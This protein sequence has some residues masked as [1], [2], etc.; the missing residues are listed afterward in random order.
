MVTKEQIKSNWLYKCV[1][2]RR[3]AV[4]AL[5]AV[6]ERLEL[7]D[8]SIGSDFN[9][10]VKALIDQAKKE[11]A[12]LENTIENSIITAE[13]KETELK[14]HLASLS[15]EHLKEFLDW[16]AKSKE[17]NRG[18]LDAPTIPILITNPNLVLNSC[19]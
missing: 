11:V 4:V 3:Q 12:M 15:P 16:A 1:E 17:A 6:L 7:D 10:G 13:R 14:E 19:L 9:Q 8:F 2:G 18:S 5:E